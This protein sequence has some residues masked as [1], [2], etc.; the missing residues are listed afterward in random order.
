MSR[1]IFVA[2]ALAV[3]L[4]L[5]FVAISAGDRTRSRDRDRIVRGTMSRTGEIADV[6]ST[7]DERFRRTAPGIPVE[8]IG[9]DGTSSPNA[10][11]EDF[12]G[13]SVVEKANRYVQH[14]AFQED[15][16][17]HNTLSTVLEMGLESVGTGRANRVLAS[18]YDALAEIHSAV[19]QRREYLHQKA[20]A[21]LNTEFER[22]AIEGANGSGAEADFAFRQQ[23]MSVDPLA[24]SDFGPDDTCSG[25]P[26]VGVPS[27]TTMSIEAPGDLNFLEIVISGPLGVALEIETTS[28]GC[29]DV[30]SCST[31]DFDTDLNLYGRCDN[32]FVDEIVARDINFGDGGLGWLSKVQTECLLPGSY[33]LEVKGQ[34]GA[35]PQNFDV[36]VREIG[37]CVVPVA[38]SYEPDDTVP[39]GNDIGYSTS[40]PSQANA[41]GRQKKEIQ[42]H[43]IF[44]PN[45]TDNMIVKLNDQTNLVKMTSQTEFQSVW[46]GQNI[47]AGTEED[48]QMLLYYG[49]DPHGGICNSAPLMIPNNYCQSSADCDPDATPA[50]PTRPADA[51]IPLYELR[52]P[53]EA[54]SRFQPFNPLAFNEDIGPSNLGSQLELCLPRTQP[55]S[56]PALV[57]NGGG[58]AIS[59][60]G[61]RPPFPGSTSELAYDYQVRSLNQGPCLYEQEP[62][63]SFPD[64]SPIEPNTPVNGIWEGSETYPLLDVDIYGPFDFQQDSRV[65][66]DVFPELLNPLVGKAVVELWVGPNDSGDFFNLNVPDEGTAP[67]ARFSVIAPPADDLLG[68]TMADAG[69]YV[70]VTSSTVVPNWYYELRLITPRV[71]AVDEEPNNALFETQNVAYRGLTIIDAAIDG[72]C[73]FDR[74][75][76]TATDPNFLDMYTLGPTDTVMQF[77]QKVGI[78]G[79]TI[80]SPASLAGTLTDIG[81][82]ADI[83]PV[84]TVDNFYGDV[85]EAIDDDV[86]GVTWDACEPLLNDMTGKVCL[87]TRGAC[88][89]VTKNLNCQAAGARATLL[90]N[91]SAGPAPGLGGDCN[92]DGSC[93][94]PIISMT[95]D[96]GTA[97][98]AN[99]PAFVQVADS[100]I[101]GCDDDTDLGT[102]NPYLSRMT[103]CVPPGDY[104]VSIRG[105]YGSAGPYVLNI[106]G[107]PGCTPEDPPNMNDSGIGSSRFCP[108]D[109][110]FDNGC[111]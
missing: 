101:I 27:I 16:D 47:P 63:Q 60:R 48:S 89:F 6:A 94:I 83:G 108:P 95:L 81:L 67:N 34:F 53:G 78:Y 93:E 5:V 105:W 72:F 102:G 12:Y 55:G 49:K 23:D 7:F 19:P 17:A 73:D 76:F 38:D 44:P 14:A 57:Q 35:T 46:G 58:F 11:V 66:A 1:K 45:D 97:L 54:R 37:T 9:S 3:C 106:T 10:V 39:E 74:F 62:N 90:V 30:V 65:S 8:I 98:R 15:V 111:N 20:Q 64:A 104:V 36:E 52:V 28:D 79:L 77:R 61:W 71:D 56:G 80:D 68:N 31:P 110:P 24:P 100:D 42:S 82:G 85:V 88:A 51:C 32:G 22:R 21:L 107:L 69:Y 59:S 43:S 96:D 84:P 92:T 75:E 40:V 18:A 50:D 109:Y 87:V 25:A 2:T 99:L 41:Y 4:A 86:T 33:Y 29:N 70:V 91:S 13:F 26:V 103:G